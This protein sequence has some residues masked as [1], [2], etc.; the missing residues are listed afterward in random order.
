MS[1]LLV[2]LD[3]PPRERWRLGP[4]DVVAARELLAEYAAD[5][6]GLERHQDLLEAYAAAQVPADY[7]A[8]LDGLA[9]RLEVSRPSILLANLYYDALKTYLMACTA[10]ALD[11]PNGPIHARNLDWHS[12]NARLARHT[13]RV[14]LQ[15]GGRPRALLASWPGFTGVLSGVAPGRF[16]VTLNSVLSDD[17]PEL[18]APIVYVLRRLLEEAA[19]FREAVDELTRVSVASD[20][21]L[22][23]TGTRPGELVVIERAPRRAAVREA[24]DGLLVVTNDYRGLA[25]SGRAPGRELAASACGR[26][27][28][29]RLLAGARR[30]TT[31]DDCLA[32]LRD[33]QVV[34]GITVQQMVLSARDGLLHVVPRIAGA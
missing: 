18:A 20:S 6:G 9:T 34:M 33:P 17:P 7:L 19:S 26:F 3:A 29:A 16:A 30:P 10:F 12:E 15:R 8:E 23:V 14:T 11:T 1:D 31:I 4:A 22:L 32:I 21:L 2:D 24:E 27:D 5:L 13:R 25:A 28:R